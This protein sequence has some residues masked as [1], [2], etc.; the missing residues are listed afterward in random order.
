[1]LRIAGSMFATSLKSTIKLCPGFCTY[2]SVS[3]SPKKRHPVSSGCIDL[4]RKQ[5]L[6]RVFF[7]KTLTVHMHAPAFSGKPLWAVVLGEIMQESFEALLISQPRFVA[8]LPVVPEQLFGLSQ[9]IVV[10]VQYVQIN[11][12]WFCPTV[13]VASHISM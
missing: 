5:N 9:Q 7:F 10:Y 4:S 13:L 3:V 11:L 6:N 12:Q 2:S 8:A 1:M